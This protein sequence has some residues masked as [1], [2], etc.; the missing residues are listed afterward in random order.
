MGLR[1]SHDHPEIV[2]NGAQ[3]FFLLSRLSSAVNAWG[4]ARGT[5]AA[6]GAP[7]R[8]KNIE[9]LLKGAAPTPMKIKVRR[10]DPDTM[11]PHR[12]LMFVGRRGVGK[13]V[14][15]ED[16]MSRLRVDYTVAM[17]PTE[18]SAAMFRK[19]V[20]ESGIFSTFNI[21]KIDS[22]VQLQRQMARTPAKLRSALLVLDDCMYEKKAFKHV[23]VRDIF[24]NGRHSHITMALT[25]QYCL[26]LSPDLRG[27]CDYVF[28]FRDTVIS[29][30]QR[31]WKYFF[32]MFE[33]Y[34]DF[35]R[36]M[37]ACCENFGCL[38][39]DNTAKD[40]DIESCVFWWKADP[41][42]AP[43]RLGRPVFWRMDQAC[44]K[45]DTDLKREHDE[46]L[47]EQMLL[48]QKKQKRLITYVERADAQG[49]ALTEDSALI[50]K[51]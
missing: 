29:N 50:M 51:V 16:I 34:Q 45:S 12:I 4:A 10:F 25:S 27:N 11:K 23:S 7:E 39:L 9:A 36:V 6:W 5:R 8:G 43:F 47:R 40:N 20:P 46:Q 31:L 44:R 24:M 13:S 49:H 38:V 22:M 3:G 15:L 18:D 48:G 2:Q 17:T 19:H 41:Q 21:A 28:V 1:R 33:T 30:K 26:D 42:V 37:D 35:S 14:A 32:G